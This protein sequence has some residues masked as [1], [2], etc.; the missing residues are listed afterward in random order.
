MEEK[1]LKSS[2][3]SLISEEYNPSNVISTQISSPK[4]MSRSEICDVLQRIAPLEKD[5][6]II[7]NDHDRSTPTATIIHYLREL[8]K[9]PFPVT[10]FVA[11]G[12][13]SPTPLTAAQKLSDWKEGDKLVVHNCDN[14]NQHTFVGITSRKTEV[15]VEN[16]V[17]TAKN[18][19]TINSVEP[20]YFA[21]FT[22]GIKSIIPGLA[23]RKTVEQNHRWAMKQESQI[24]VTEGNPLFEDLWEAGN[25]CRDLSQIQTIQM[26]NHGEQIKYL[27][28]G[29]LKSAF[30]YAKLAALEFFGFSM[31]EKVDHIIS[32]VAPPL[33]RTL[34]QA[35]KSME[36]V[37]KVLKDG[38]TF[39]LIAVC[40][41][42]I[43][44]SNFFQRFLSYD[45]PQSLI[46]KLSFKQYKFGDHK[47][48]YWGKL[49][50]RAQIYYMGDLS[51]E[52]IQTA[53]MK[54][55]SL[56]YLTNLLEKWNKKKETLLVDVAGGFTS[57]YVKK[58]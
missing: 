45:S 46:K 40:D 32:F 30:N 13:H 33:D 18:I 36:N 49:A 48:F 31:T 8:Q 39:L 22:G 55:I 2:I 58:D 14:Y 26:I 10:F 56:D 17:V 53:F 4:Y 6:V 29:S 28:V 24:L 41:D 5:T 44:N 7:I 43:G 21:G 15:W 51:D 11:T 20:H 35:Q 27:A 3:L 54:K 47:A 23:A 19:L 37:K 50:D 25:L 38:G 9:I 1:S 52:Q 34:Y 57:C 16:L 42:G 12:T